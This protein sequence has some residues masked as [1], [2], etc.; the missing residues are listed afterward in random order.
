VIG[1]F[2][3]D[4]PSDRSR[5]VEHFYKQSKTSTRSMGDIKAAREAKDIERVKEILEDK[6]ADIALAQ[7][8]QHGRAPDGEINRQIKVANA[9]KKSAEEKRAEIDRWTTIRN[10]LA[11]A[12][13]KRRLRESEK[14]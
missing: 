5:Y 1:D 9:S 3:K 11:A 4:L 8:L 13:E 14:L 10:E 2:V 12:V 6:K 7:P